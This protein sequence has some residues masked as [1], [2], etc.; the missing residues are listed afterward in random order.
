MSFYD[1]APGAH[2]VELMMVD[3][4]YRPTH[5]NPWRDPEL[6]AIAERDAL[7]EERAA[8]DDQIAYLRKHG[9]D[10]LRRALDA[11][12]RTRRRLDGIPDPSHPDLRG[13]KNTG[14]DER[15]EWAS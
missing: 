5:S 2:H 14:T 13:A 4:T 3:P 15:A 7:E 12:E 10:C 9:C 6:E 1:D 11:W 8:L